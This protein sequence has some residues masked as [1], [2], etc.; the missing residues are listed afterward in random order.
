ML[1]KGSF[2]AFLR[3]R[4]DEM[5]HFYDEN[6][7]STFGINIQVRLIEIRLGLNIANGELP[8]DLVS[9]GCWCQL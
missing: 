1:T 8:Q 6:P 9:A 7:V 2:S 4:S 5:R 3:I